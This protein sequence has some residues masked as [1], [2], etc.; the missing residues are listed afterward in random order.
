MIS[1]ADL[2]LFNPFPLHALLSGMKGMRATRRVV[3]AHAAH[4][5]AAEYA[6]GVSRWGGRASERASERKS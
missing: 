5:G 3:L 1:R 2:E 6:Q 4:V